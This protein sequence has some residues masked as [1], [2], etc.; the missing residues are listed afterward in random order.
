MFIYDVKRRRAANE[1]I[2]T[3]FLHHVC[4]TEEI[5]TPCNGSSDLDCGSR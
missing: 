1:E 2:K 5:T 3:M 4:A